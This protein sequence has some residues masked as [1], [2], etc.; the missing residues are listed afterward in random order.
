MLL[1]TAMTL[2]LLLLVSVAIFEL[3][4]VYQAEQVLTNAAREGA[5]LAIL[6]NSSAA[7]IQ[8][9]VTQYLQA[10]QLPNSQSA[11]VTVTPNAVIA[12]GGTNVSASIVTVNYPYQFTFLNPVARLVVSG[13]TLGGA[14]LMLTASAEMR[15]ETQF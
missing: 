11:T 14:P 8:S 13:S 9:R 6:P 10:G 3:A 2:P 15:N 12:M 4:T 1:E 7:D 5:R